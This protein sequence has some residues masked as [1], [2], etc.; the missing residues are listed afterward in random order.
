MSGIADNNFPAFHRWAA[1]L[2]ADGFDVVSPAEIEEADTWELCLRAGL[3]EL[4]TCDAIALMPGWE[5]SRGAH[6]EL[7]V[8][9]RLGMKVMH[10]TGETQDADGVSAAARALIAEAAR[11]G[12]VLN[13][14]QRPLQPLAM[15][16]HETVA[17][18]RPARKGAGS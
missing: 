11:L 2:R 15:G 3:R 9:H 8:A 4:C 1:K 10:L 14:E 18:V 6:L 17:S 5:G 13:I 12:L 16:H 7:H